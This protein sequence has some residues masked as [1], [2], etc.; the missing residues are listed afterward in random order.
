MEKSLRITRLEEQFKRDL[1]VLV[2]EKARDPRIKDVTVLG[3]EVSKDLEYAKVYVS[4]IGDDEAKKQAMAVLKAASG[5]FRTELA[6][7][8]DIRKVPELRFILDN[9]IE[10]GMRIDK[11]LSELGYPRKD[12]QNN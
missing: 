5:Y 4:I 3:V 11:L 7:L 12:E 8:H 6:G 1:G 2:L 9:S 10:H